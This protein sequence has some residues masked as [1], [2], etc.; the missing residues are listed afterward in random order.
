VSNQVRQLD[1]PER[2]DLSAGA[3]QRISDAIALT[4]RRPTGRRRLVLLLSTVVLVGVGSVLM[5]SRTESPP[6]ADMPAPVLHLL[7]RYADQEP[8]LSDARLAATLTTPSGK[9]VQ[10]WQ[11][12][13]QNGGRCSVVVVAG[14]AVDSACSSRA[15]IRMRHGD[16]WDGAFFDPTGH[17]GYADGAA[18]TTASTVELRA[19]YLPRPV[20]GPIVNG[21]FYLELPPASPPDKSTG[22]YRFLDAN[23]HLIYGYTWNP[24]GIDMT[25]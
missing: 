14:R 2:Y 4:P 5:G 22:S 11:A 15:T 20:V 12:P 1:W 16:A 19:S 13:T 8:I 17:D 7:Q 9:A 18:P 10:F 23:G 21:Y 25:P 24:D 6:A 3:M